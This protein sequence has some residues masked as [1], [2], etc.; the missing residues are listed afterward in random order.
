MPLHSTSRFRE[1]CEDADPLKALSY[2]QT[3]VSAVVD[4]TDAEETRLFRSLL[5]HLLSPHGALGS[6]SMPTAKKRSREESSARK[7]DD[8]VADDD[9]PMFSRPHSPVRTTSSL[10]PSESASIVGS[11]PLLSYVPDASERK[12]NEG[13]APSAARFKQRTQV[14]EELMEYVNDDAKQPDKDLMLM[15]NVDQEDP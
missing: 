4:H 13:N 1:L 7:D 12:I 9:D 11:R 3:E 5:S 8:K 2:L 14:F 15:I 10:T 6:S